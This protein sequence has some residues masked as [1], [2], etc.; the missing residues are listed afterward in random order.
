ML[1]PKTKRYISQ[2]IPFGLIWFVFSIIY[3]IIEKGLLGDSLYYPSTGNPY[4]FKGSFLITITISTI[5]G[6]LL[7]TFEVLYLNKLFSKRRFGQKIFFK[8]II[9]V[10]IMITFLLVNTIISNSIVGYFSVVNTLLGL[11]C[12]STVSV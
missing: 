4:N 11:E 8:T 12:S 1:V 6:L 2:I 9:Y 7:G 5:T 10:A 3:M